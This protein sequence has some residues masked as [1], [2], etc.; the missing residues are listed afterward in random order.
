[1]ICDSMEERIQIVKDVL[2]HALMYTGQD[3]EINADRMKQWLM[4]GVSGF[5]PQWSKKNI[6]YIKNILTKRILDDL[7]EDVILKIE[8][9]KNNLYSSERDLSRLEMLMDEEVGEL[10]ENMEKAAKEEKEKNRKYSMERDLS[11]LEMLVDEEVEELEENTKKVVKEENGDNI[12]KEQKDHNEKKRKK[13]EKKKNKKAR[14]K[15]R[16]G[17]KKHRKKNGVNNIKEETKR[18]MAEDG[19]ITERMVEELLE[20]VEGDPL[21]VDTGHPAQIRLIESWDGSNDDGNVRS[22]FEV[23]VDD[24]LGGRHVSPPLSRASPLEYDYGCES[25]GISYEYCMD[26]LVNV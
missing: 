23:E 16:E 5:L 21:A 26:H 12:E 1:M 10:E 18:P 19:S 7:T 17:E 24:G 20:K 6:Q 22:T 25:D 9:M 14:K 4:S 11:R 13:E 2:P 3:N 15:K 8:Y